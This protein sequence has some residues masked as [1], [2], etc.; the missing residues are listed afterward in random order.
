MKTKLLRAV[1]TYNK[2]ET[3]ENFE[4]LNKAR[5]EWYTTPAG[6]QSLSLALEGMAKGV[7]RTQ[8]KNEFERGILRRRLALE[9]YKAER[10]IL[11]YEQPQLED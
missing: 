1:K 9:L 5:E 8:L 3:Y 4:S 6:Q 10:V 7:L 2:N 11:G